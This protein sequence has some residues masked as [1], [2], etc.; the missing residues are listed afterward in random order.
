MRKS[1]IWIGAAAILIVAVLIAVARHRE[2]PIVAAPTLLPPTPVAAAPAQTPATTPPLIGP[3]GFAPLQ[4][5]AVKDAIHR[6][7]T[8]GATQRWQDG[9]LSGYAVPSA[10]TG[11]NGCRAIRY[12][13]DQMPDAAYGSITACDAS[14]H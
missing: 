12:T 6:A 8:T 2:R 10:T 4:S 11:A 3:G 13:I 9:T 1:I 5:Q 14:A 7:L